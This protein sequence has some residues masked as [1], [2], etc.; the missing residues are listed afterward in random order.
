MAL[1]I[2]NDRLHSTIHH[3]KVG[4]A[5]LLSRIRSMIVTISI[6]ASQQIVR[7]SAIA[8]KFKIAA[9]K[10]GW[11]KSEILEGHSPLLKNIRMKQQ[12]FELFYEI[13]DEEE[14]CWKDHNS[15]IKV[16]ACPIQGSISIQFQKY[17]NCNKLY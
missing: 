4:Y 11:F 12:N 2:F 17:P 6:S 3:L 5:T 13:Y 14:S 10:L 16:M 7:F 15:L 9:K 8:T 1:L